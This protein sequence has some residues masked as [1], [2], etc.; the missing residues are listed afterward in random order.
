M[1]SINVLAIS[2]DN[3]LLVIIDNK[4]NVIGFDVESLPHM[5]AVQLFNITGYVHEGKSPGSMFFQC[6]I[7]F[8]TFSF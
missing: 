2:K 3:D 5:K 8:S 4:N 1:E 6:G 7:H